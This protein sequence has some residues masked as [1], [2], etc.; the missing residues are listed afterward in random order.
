MRVN[1]LL[2][3]DANRLEANTTYIQTSQILIYVD[4]S[5]DVHVSYGQVFTLFLESSSND[6]E[7]DLDDNAQ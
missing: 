7:G 3:R 1:R 6:E 4:V 2:G 5:K